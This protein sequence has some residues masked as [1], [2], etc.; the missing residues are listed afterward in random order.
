MHTC[1]SLTVDEQQFGLP[2]VLIEA[3]S[4]SNS[5]SHLDIIEVV[6]KNGTFALYCFNGVVQR[7][8]TVD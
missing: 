4:A 8:S 7:S 5:H 3:A 1:T 6:V 2:L